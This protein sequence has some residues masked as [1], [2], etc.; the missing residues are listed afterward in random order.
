M[1]QAICYDMRFPYHF[2]CEAANVEAYCVIAAWGGKR[3]EHWKTLLRARA[4]ENQAYVLGVNRIGEEPNLNYSG[5][6]AIIDPLGNTVLDCGENEGAF[7]ESVDIS[8]VLEWRND[9]PA[10]KDRRS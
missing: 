4:I 2:W 3:A 9:F 5:N 6:S 8:V 10:L 1:G 7:T